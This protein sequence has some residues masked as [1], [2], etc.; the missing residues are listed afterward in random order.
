M[1]PPPPFSVDRLDRESAETPAGKPSGWD[2][3]EALAVRFHAGELSLLAARTGHGKTSALVGLLVNWLKAAER[4]RTDELFVF[5]SA[6]E[7]EVRVYHRLLAYLTAEERAWSSWDSNEVRDY[8]RDPDSRGPDYLWPKEGDLE[9][10]KVLLGAL[11]SRLL[12]VHRPAWTVDELAA[13]A[14]DLSRGRTVGAVLADYLQRIPPP[15]RG[16]RRDIEVSAVARRLHHL[17]G[18]LSAPVVTAAQ[19]NR[20]AVPDKYREGL[21]KAGD[22]EAAKDVIRKAR[23]ELYHLREG[24]SEQE[25]DLVLGL[26]NYA[27]DY[28][29]TERTGRVPDVTR[30]EIGTLKTRY[31]TPGRWAALAFEGRYGL[32]RDPERTGEV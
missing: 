8:L 4:G 5:Y 22:Y 25:A 28:R 3:L 12:V 10:A 32:L 24:G 16:D 27:A 21:S 9:A 19:I 1:E 13:H 11:G 15:A 14:L 18:E 20:E 30:F 7:P 26:L 29:E 31:G 17:A 23:P 2:A 6:E